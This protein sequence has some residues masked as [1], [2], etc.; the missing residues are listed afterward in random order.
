MKKIIL[1]CHNISSGPAGTVQDPEKSWYRHPGLFNC[2]FVKE[3]AGGG[4][5]TLMEFFLPREYSEL[6]PGTRPE[7]GNKELKISDELNDYDKAGQIDPA[8]YLKRWPMEL[9]QQAAIQKISE[10]EVLERRRVLM[11]G[12]MRL[13]AAA[14]GSDV[15][16][17]AADAQEW[18]NTLKMELRDFPQFSGQSDQEIA[19]GIYCGDYTKYKEFRQFL[20]IA[21]CYS[22]ILISACPVLEIIMK[23]DK[24]KTCP[25]LY[26]GYLWKK[27]HHLTDWR[28]IM[29]LK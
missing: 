4:A 9:D 20:R 10:A 12:F 6:V 8:P 11:R 18:E 25:A 5:I 15:E 17:I 28:K 1:C 13:T 3:K 29:A 16:A 19:E 7:A 2:S 14:F 27:H 22:E 21:S 26:A 23:F 24:G